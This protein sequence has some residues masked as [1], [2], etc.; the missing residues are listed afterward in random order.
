VFACPRGHSFDVARSGYLNLLQPQDRRSR[1]PGDSKEAAAAR[2]RL[3]LAGHGEALLR[4][5]LAAVAGLSLPHRPAVLDAGC[6]E[7]SVLAAVARERAGEACGVDIS[8]PA[9]E[10]AARACP[11]ATWIVANA[12]R[13]LPFAA[14][15]FD[16]VMSI[17]ARQ[18]PA[19][20]RRV[21]APAGQLLVAVPGADDLIELREV[22]GGERRLRDRRERTLAAFAG[23]FELVGEGAAHQ[24]EQLDAASLGDLL[25]I[26]YR[27]GRQR[28]RRRLAGLDGLEVTLSQDLLVL[29]PRSAA[30][31]AAP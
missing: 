2:R 4:G 27:G 6:G 5:V 17:T 29:R 15:S 1:H 3:Y 7:G 19:E 23:E 8:V 30:P 31:A 12:D 11:Q 14:G 10:L 16:L 22:L 25:A 24:R 13:F 20:F 18:N 21:L 26:T 28:E 9:I